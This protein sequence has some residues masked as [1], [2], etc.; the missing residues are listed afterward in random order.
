MVQHDIATAPTIK[1]LHGGADTGQGWFLPAYLGVFLHA[2]I[3][4]ELP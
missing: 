1:A 2:S 3:N 4:P